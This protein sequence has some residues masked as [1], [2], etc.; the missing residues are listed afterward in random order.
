MAKGNSASKCAK[1]D[2]VN[3][4]PAESGGASGEPADVSRNAGGPSRNSGNPVGV[5]GVLNAAVLCMMVVSF[6]ATSGGLSEFVFVDHPFRAALVSFAL[7]SVI[8]ILSLRLP[9]YLRMCSEAKRSRL[10]QN[11]K[12][13]RRIWLNWR[14]AVLIL[15]FGASLTGSVA[16]DFVFLS[17][18]AYSWNNEGA[19][20]AQ[21]YVEDE[22][23]DILRQAEVIVDNGADA[24]K[25]ELIEELD[26]IRGEFVS[27]D[28]AYADLAQ[29]ESYSEDGNETFRL[30]ADRANALIG[31]FSQ[32]EADALLNDVQSYID[33]ET[34][35]AATQRKNSEDH[36][37][38]ANRL[39]A[40][41]QSW[42]NTA[43]QR[44]YYADLAASETQAAADAAALADAAERHV[45]DA[46]TVK[47][48]V[49]SLAVDGSN[50]MDMLLSQVVGSLVS[51]EQ[52]D[53][54]ESA[55]QDSLESITEL[56][57][58][59]VSSDSEGGESMINKLGLVEDFKSAVEDYG[60]ITAAR[61][62]VRFLRENPSEIPEDYASNDF[63]DRWNEAWNG[64]FD[65]LA[66]SLRSLPAQYQDEGGATD[67]LWR[68]N[69][70]SRDYLGELNA[71][72]KSVQY[73][74]SRYNA[75]AI[76]TLLLAL[77]LDLAAAGIGL[78]LYARRTA[79]PNQAQG[80]KFAEGASAQS[81]MQT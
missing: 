20:Y 71:L 31:S 65:T 16:F 55:L 1:D 33:S 8:F 34:A 45:R 50:R 23:D 70:I 80:R 66:T 60:A 41:S 56:L 77:Y 44:Q 62:S 52:S 46:E 15:V 35:S 51:S 48:F 32:S 13:E 67:L 61:S 28:S 74:I 59:S 64:R 4:S 68:I 25:R 72:E 38:E 78:F 54:G 12:P 7:Q 75:L 36:R 18:T 29:L 42:V 17:N 9:L 22:Y 53:D 57:V 14:S 5:E 76:L 37:S 2:A 10:R 6:L 30:L 11:G 81:W 43:D 47:S 63:E 69:D 26:A 40:S 73:L 27:D 21:I 58:D 39:I 79:L 3:D 49:A 19:R 24:A